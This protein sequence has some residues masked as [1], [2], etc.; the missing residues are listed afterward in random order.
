RAGCVLSALHPARV[1]A[2]VTIGGYTIHNIAE[3][4]RPEDPEQEAR[5]WYQWYF[6]TER[7]RAGLAANRREV[8]RLLWRTWSPGWRVDDATPHRPPPS[9]DKPPFVHLLLHS[10]RH[11]DPNAPRQPPLSAA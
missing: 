1:R 11:R 10:Y 7:G 5:L 8:C 2:L 9:P 4:A 6:N 3:M